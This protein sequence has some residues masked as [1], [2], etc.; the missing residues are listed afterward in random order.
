MKH[1]TNPHCHNMLQISLA[2][3]NVFASFFSTR[4]MQGFVQKWAISLAGPNCL[5]QEENACYLSII[6]ERQAKIATWV[7]P[8]RSSLPTIFLTRLLPVPS[9]I[10]TPSPLSAL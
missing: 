3:E 6:P 1:I 8:A 7:R 5:G 4:D 2:S 10:T 9:P